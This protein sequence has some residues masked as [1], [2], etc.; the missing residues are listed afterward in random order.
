LLLESRR[1]FRVLRR[2]RAARR[3]RLGRCRRLLRF[4]RFLVAALSL[5]HGGLL[6]GKGWLISQVAPA[7]ST[8]QALATADTRSDEFF[9]GTVAQPPFSTKSPCDQLSTFLSAARLAGASPACWNL[10]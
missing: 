8:A 9:P 7:S 10:S 4:L 3:Q 1:R 2:R 5:G 6:Q